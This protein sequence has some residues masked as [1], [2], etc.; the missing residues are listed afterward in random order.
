V[1]E[2]TVGIDP[3][4]EGMGAQSSQGP[5]R[6]ALMRGAREK[7][8]MSVQQL[9]NGMN[10][11][12]KQILALEADD[13]AA[14]PAAT[15]VRGFVRN[16]ARIVGCD[17]SLF[18]VNHAEHSDKPESPSLKLAP[19]AENMPIQSNRSDAN[20]RWMFAAAIVVVIG[21]IGGYLKWEH[22]EQA[23][24]LMSPKV[25]SG[26][27]VV[28][29]LSAEDQPA[30]PPTP[31]PQPPALSDA[32]QPPSKAEGPAAPITPTRAA[33]EPT[34]ASKASPAD[35]NSDSAP[36]ASSAPRLDPSLPA[37]PVVLDLTQDSWMDVHEIGGKVFVH[38]IVKA[39]E[40]K[41][42]EA[43]GKVRVIIGNAPGVSL[44]WKGKA[45]DLSDSTKDSVAKLTLEPS[46]E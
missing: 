28:P 24:N 25:D 2:D 40:H 1:S 43:R 12:Q 32:N 37:F 29:K 18:E 27:A 8:G 38:G 46:T 19:P 15:F 20:R 35:P 42:F 21:L 3:M 41:E 45:M 6:G 30:Q 39:G 22:I 9:A 10:L 17:P 4:S 5:S 16:Y 31:A 36:A 34:G 13:L 23:R 26:V 33:A 44:S 11:S 7:A 14:L